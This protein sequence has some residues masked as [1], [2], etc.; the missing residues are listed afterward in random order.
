MRTAISQFENS[1]LVPLTNRNTP[2]RAI[3]LSREAAIIILSRCVR[4]LNAM[5]AATLEEREN[6][7]ES[8]AILT[9]LRLELSRESLPQ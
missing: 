2:P 1:L 3:K 4:A 8:A 5:R 9:A 6:A 7:R